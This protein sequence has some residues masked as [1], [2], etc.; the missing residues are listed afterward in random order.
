MS[1]GPPFRGARP[2]PPEKAF[3]APAYRP[4]E[5]PESPDDLSNQAEGSDAHQTSADSP[6]YSACPGSSSEEASKHVKN[7]LDGIAG[8]LKNN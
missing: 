7:L 2:S 8:L 1:S 3:A 4:E 6:S 5:G